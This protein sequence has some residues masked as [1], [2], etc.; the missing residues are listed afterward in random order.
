MRPRIGPEYSWALRLEFARNWSAAAQRR[1]SSVPAPL[2][3]SEGAIQCIKELTLRRRQSARQPVLEVSH[4]HSDSGGILMKKPFGAI[5]IV[6]ARKG[7]NG[8]DAVTLELA[9]D[10]W[11]PSHNE[12]RRL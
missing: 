8:A 12:Q 9:P 4:R 10:S 11:L 3:F 6:G 5:R 7:C 2:S 1:F